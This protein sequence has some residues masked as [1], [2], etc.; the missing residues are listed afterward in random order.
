MVRQGFGFLEGTVSEE[1]EDLGAAGVAWRIMTL[2]PVDEGFG[3][4]AELVGGLGDFEF[5]VHADGALE[6]AEAASQIGV[7]KETIVNWEQGHS[8][9]P[10]RHGPKILEFLGYWPFEEPESLGDRMRLWRWKRGLNGDEAAAAIGVDPCSWSSWERGEHKPVRAS[11]ERLSRH[12]ILP[13]P[14]TE[15]EVQAWEH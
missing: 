5:P 1:C 14:A 9:P 15:D 6:I 13:S 7:R 2:F 11:R 8:T 4:D 10:Y 12:R 3:G